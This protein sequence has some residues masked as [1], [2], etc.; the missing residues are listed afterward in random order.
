MLRTR[1]KAYVEAV[2][3]SSIS[4]AISAL[5]SRLFSI[6]LVLVLSAWTP[7]YDSSHSGPPSYAGSGTQLPSKILLICPRE[8]NCFSSFEGAVILVRWRTL[9]IEEFGWKH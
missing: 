3:E 1:S 5:A 9:Y 4:L 7:P 2:S 6:A 8:L